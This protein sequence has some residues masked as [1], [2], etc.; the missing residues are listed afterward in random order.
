MPEKVGA[1]PNIGMTAQGLWKEGLYGPSAQRIA[2]Q[3]VPI[4]DQVSITQK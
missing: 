2:T 3:D 4:T 1:V